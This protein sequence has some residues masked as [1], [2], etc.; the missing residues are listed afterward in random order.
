M[1]LVKKAF[2]LFWKG[3]KNTG[4]SFWS[5]YYSQFSPI[6]AHRLWLLVSSAEVQEKNGHWEWSLR[7][8]FLEDSVTWLFL[9]DFRK[10]DGKPPFISTSERG[11]SQT[12]A[13]QTREL[14]VSWVSTYTNLIEFSAFSFQA[15]CEPRLT[16]Q[17]VLNVA[18]VALSNPFIFSHH[19]SMKGKKRLPELTLSQFVLSWTGFSQWNYAQGSK[20]SYARR[21]G[22]GRKESFYSWG[23]FPLS[24]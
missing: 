9:W 17:T 23:L 12:T 6:S 20:D 22:R 7:H 3:L 1:D 4:Y 24:S 8:C 10:A 15:M 13:K 2:P 5:I 14:P 18:Q 21:A 19:Q 16:Q 11:S